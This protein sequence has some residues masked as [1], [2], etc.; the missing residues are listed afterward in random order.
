MADFKKMIDL[1]LARK[2][3]TDY[4][5]AQDFANG[6]LHLKYPNK[7]HSVK[8]EHGYLVYT[9]DSQ[10]LFN[11]VLKEILNYVAQFQLTDV[12]W[13]TPAQI[14]ELKTAGNIFACETEFTKTRY[15]V[16][17]SVFVWFDDDTQAAY[18][19]HERSATD[20]YLKINMNIDELYLALR[21]LRFNDKLIQYVLPTLSSNVREYFI[22][23]DII[24]HNLFTLLA[25]S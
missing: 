16:I 11:N 20:S 10:K 6:V 13:A 15:G 8:N 23:G 17:E 24:S 22:T 3:T 25:N 14:A 19:Q 5:Y 2:I 7:L 9:D 1:D 21:E 18:V 4:Q 12:E